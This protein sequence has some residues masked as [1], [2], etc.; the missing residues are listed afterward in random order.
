M[1]SPPLRAERVTVFCF[2]LFRSLFPRSQ[3]SQWVREQIQTVFRY[4]VTAAPAI[5][6][7][8]GYWTVRRGRRFGYVA[9]I[10]FPITN[11][12]SPI[13]RASLA[14]AGASHLSLFTCPQSPNL[15]TSHQSRPR[16]RPSGAL[17]G[18]LPC[19]LT[20]HFAF[21]IWH[22]VLPPSPSLRRGKLSSSSGSG[23]WQQRLAKLRR[24]RL[25][26]F[27]Q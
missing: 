26:R 5:R 16:W 1:S 15:L 21:G 25:R 20:R 24:Q 13:R 12:F 8:V 6:Q 18:S 9:S 27:G 2:R 7:A 17:P 10:A 14:Q 19:I 4:V 22:F 11:H 3:K 23:Y